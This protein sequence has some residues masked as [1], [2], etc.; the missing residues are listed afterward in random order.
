M[1]HEAREIDPEVL[2]DLRLRESTERDRA[3]ANAAIYDWRR[4]QF[5]GAWPCRTC[6]TLVPVQASDLENV[7][8][9]N[10]ILKARGEEPIEVERVMFCDDCRALHKDRGAGKRREQNER[11]AEEIRKLKAAPDPDRER[12]TINTLRDLGHPDVDGLLHELRERAGSTSKAKASRGKQAV[13]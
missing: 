6:S 10:R 4:P 5:C 13:L 2:A 7:A 9:W 12:A 11:L 3:P 8:M 1:K